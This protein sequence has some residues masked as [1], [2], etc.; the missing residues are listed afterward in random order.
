MGIIAEGMEW[1]ALG[2]APVTVVEEAKEQM[3]KASDQTSKAGW[4][5]VLAEAYIATCKPTEALDSASEALATFKGAGLKDLELKAVIVVAKA[6]VMKQEWDDAIAAYT[7]A[8]DHCVTLGAFGEQAAVFVALAEAYL[9]Q[10]KDPYMAARSALSAVQVY[11]DLDDKKGM[12]K[13]L[14]VAADAHL[15]YDPEAA[16]KVAKDGV[17]ACEEV[18]DIQ[19]K[20]EMLKLVAAAKAQIGTSQQA[21]SAGSF[22]A[23]GDSHIPYKWPKVP[24]QEGE[25]PPDAF[26]VQDYAPPEKSKHD[27]LKT[28]GPNF[29]KRSFKWTMGRHQTDGAWFR[30]ELHYQPPKN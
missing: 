9:K 23:R 6:D 30:Q 18:G 24:Q 8:L 10:M 28:K 4:K 25:C 26:I 17:A 14:L 13:S 2:E 20:A 21:E 29:T 19:S 3:Q 5:L 12:V 11:G 15:L 7:T 27:K 1:L 16:L 22:A